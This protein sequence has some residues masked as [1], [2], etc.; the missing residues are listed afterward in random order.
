MLTNSWNS[1]KVE[2]EVQA[3]MRK[4]HTDFF[5]TPAA[6]QRQDAGEGTFM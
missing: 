3:M 2:I 6:E 1:V 5:P 4:P